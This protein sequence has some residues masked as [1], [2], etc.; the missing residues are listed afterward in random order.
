MKIKYDNETD[1]I[2][3]ILSS[4]TIVESEEKLKDVVVDYND[5]DEVV[6]IEILN[7]KQNEHEID[8][9]LILKSA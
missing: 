5:K 4:D 9:P 1:A 8:L 2:Y 6:A 3:V 7:V